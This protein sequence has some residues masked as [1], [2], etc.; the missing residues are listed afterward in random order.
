MIKIL[1]F[2]GGVNLGGIGAG[3]MMSHHWMGFGVQFG[4]SERN[5]WEWGLKKNGWGI[6]VG[7]AWRQPRHPLDRGV[8]DTHIPDL[9]LFRGV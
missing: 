2:G 5:A 8:G 1:L 9:G 6:G 4:C 3:E 7:F